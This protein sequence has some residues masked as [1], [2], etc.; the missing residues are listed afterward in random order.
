MPLFLLNFSSAFYHDHTKMG[1]YDN[2]SPLKFNPLPQNAA[3]LRTKDIYI[4]VE[5]IA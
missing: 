3:F 5:N 1:L 2:K 4:S